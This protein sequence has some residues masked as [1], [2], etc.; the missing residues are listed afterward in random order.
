M[1]NEKTLKKGF[2]LMELVIVIVIIG[3]LASVAIPKFYDM[4]ADAKAA[5]CKSSLATVRSAIA[6]FYAYSASP[7][8]GGSARWPTLSQLRTVGTVLD[9][10]LPDNPY[11]T[12]NDPNRVR[13]GTRAGRPVS[14]R[15][16][17]GWCYNQSTGQ[18]W[19]DTRSGVG[20]AGF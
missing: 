8:G 16:S 20:E 7:A 17:G 12:G 13:R 11:S 2:T 1:R 5:S 9:T 18:F 14:S 6:A 4:S 15:T 19:A 10:P 3:I